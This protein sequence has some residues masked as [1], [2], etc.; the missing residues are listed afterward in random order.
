MKL[1]LSC[2]KETRKYTNMWRLSNILLNN[3]S[4][5]EEIKEE[6][7]NYLGTNEYGNITFQNPWDVAKVILRGQFI[8]I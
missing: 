7:K 8:V 6:I 3:H 5:N 4:I 1:E 2:K